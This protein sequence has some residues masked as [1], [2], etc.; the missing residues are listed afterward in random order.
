[1]ASGSASTDAAARP[2]QRGRSIFFNL[3]HER[4]VGLVRKLL[5]VALPVAYSNEWY[6]NIVKTPHEFTKMG[7]CRCRAVRSRGA[8]PRRCRLRRRLSC[9]ARAVY[10]PPL[11]RAS[12]PRTRARAAFYNDIFVGVVGCQV[13]TAADGSKKLYIMALAVL[14][15]YRGY[16][17]GA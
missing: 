9:L 6:A 11:P 14:A 4:N 8:P 15:A 12:P 1:M 16:G 13:E 3:V 17:V 2:Q 7:A 5:D 10:S